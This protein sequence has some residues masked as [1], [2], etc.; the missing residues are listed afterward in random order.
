MSG[1]SGESGE[2]YDP[3]GAAEDAPVEAAPATGVA[4][5]P[6]PLPALN[7][8]PLLPLLPR[9]VAAGEEVEKKV[10]A[11][12]PGPIINLSTVMV[13]YCVTVTV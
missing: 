6:L 9:L 12:S 10:V 11:V 4:L 7:W 13:T 2:S 5:A 1:V 3:V 8:F